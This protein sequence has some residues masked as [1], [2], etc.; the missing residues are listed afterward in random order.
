MK[1]SQYDETLQCCLSTFKFG[2]SELNRL[3]AGSAVASYCEESAFLR[4]NGDVA[5]LFNLE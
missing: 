1:I 3:V 5:N 2:F 4:K